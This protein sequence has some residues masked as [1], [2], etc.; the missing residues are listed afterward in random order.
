MRDRPQSIPFEDGRPKG[1]TKILQERGINTAT[2]NADDM[3]NIL[4]NHD[5][6]VV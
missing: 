4:T 1:M 5:D 2:L 6:S 3:R